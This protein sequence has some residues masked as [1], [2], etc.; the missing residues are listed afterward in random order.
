[1]SDT[2]IRY[3]ILKKMYIDQI[4]SLIESKIMYS[5]LQQ[6]YK[7]NSIIE[8]MNDMKEIYNEKVSHVSEL[9]RVIDLVKD[10]LN[11][12]IN[13]QDFLTKRQIIEQL[14][15]LRDFASLE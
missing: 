7:E 6:D 5:Q 3:K 8:S 2:S 15:S 1:M 4:D 12:L 14:S 11:K 9:N 10:T 13:E